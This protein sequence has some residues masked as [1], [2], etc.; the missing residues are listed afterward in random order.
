MDARQKTRR[1]ADRRTPVSAGL[2]PGSAPRKT[3][4]TAAKKE[5]PLVVYTQPAP[6]N[7]NK[8]LL[9]LATVLAVV[10]AVVFG[11]SIFFKVDE[12]KIT[13]SGIN[14]YTAWDVREASGIVHGENLLTLSDAGITNRIQDKLPY[15]KWA[16]VGIELPD[17]VHIE[18]EEREV[19]YSVESENDGWWL[20]S[21]D[22]LIVDK[23]T[24]AEAS[25]YTQVL[26]VKLSA[27]EIGKQA[28]AAELVPDTSESS[29]TVPV[30]V[31]ESERL[32]AV[33]SILQFLEQSGVIGG[34]TSVDVSNM[35][36]LEIWFGK[37]YQVT[38]GDAGNL[39]YKI[40]VMKGA[41]DQMGEYHDQGVLDVSF[42]IRPDEAVF[43]KF[44]D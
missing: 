5:K 35:S 10:L 38:L 9:R 18:V 27:P 24:A 15:I 4:G 40:Q 41:M 16:R 43:T 34:A 26:G 17:T 1:R 28:A 13:V 39:Q 8:F 31:Y 2:A 21:A 12:A 19:V 23:T 29:E 25:E 6:F 3:S 7:R 32:D 37:Q 44:T 33:I 20:I 30:T 42:T 22:G 11:M 14:K 36:G